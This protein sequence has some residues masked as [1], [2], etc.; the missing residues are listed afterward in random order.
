[1][2]PGV[3]EPVDRLS[4]HL[5]GCVEVL[6]DPTD[7]VATLDGEDDLGRRVVKYLAHLE[8]TNNPVTVKR[9]TRIPIQLTLPGSP[10]RVA[11]VH[12]HRG[13]RRR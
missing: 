5:V 4:N 12:R 3:F 6:C 10:L 9:L 8:V 7:G 2:Y 11:A 1:M 13:S